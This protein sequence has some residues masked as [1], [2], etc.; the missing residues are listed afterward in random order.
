MK[1]MT[2]ALYK[3]L[4]ALYSGENDPDPMVHIKFFDPCGSWTWY[5]LEG[6]QEPR[7]PD[8]GDDDFI[9]FGLVDGF[10]VELG[11]F[12]LRELESIKGRIGIGIERDLYFVPAKL[13]KIRAGIDARRGE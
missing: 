4:P 7:T 10:E 2:K 1:L 5:V 12:S 8:P 3:T 6:S 9:F 11:N 13:S